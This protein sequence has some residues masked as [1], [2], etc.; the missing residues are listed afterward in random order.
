MVADRRGI[1]ARGED[2]AALGVV[3][4]GRGEVEVDLT[5]SIN[6]VT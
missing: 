3:D 2:L 6:R 5:R 1:D 4:L